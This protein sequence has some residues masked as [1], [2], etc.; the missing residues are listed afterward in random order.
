MDLEEVPTVTQPAYTDTVE[1][2]LE[3]T[4]LKD[5]FETKVSLVTNCKY[6]SKLKT[7]LQCKE[8]SKKILDFETITPDTEKKQTTKVPQKDKTPDSELSPKCDLDENVT[9]KEVLLQEEMTQTSFENILTKSPKDKED[10]NSIPEKEITAVEETA[11]VDK[12]PEEEK[13]VETP[14]LK[15]TPKTSM[16]SSDQV[17]SNNSDAKKEP[18]MEQE[19]KNTEEINTQKKS[20]TNLPEHMPTSDKSATIDLKMTTPQN[21]NTSRNTQ[22]SSKRG[23]MPSNIQNRNE[24]TSE[25]PQLEMICLEDIQSTS[26]MKNGKDISNINETKD[27]DIPPIKDKQQSE[28]INKEI[29]DAKSEVQT[30]GTKGEIHTDLQEH[31]KTD[32]CPNSLGGFTLEKVCKWMSM[33]IYL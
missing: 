23:K 5:T 21:K 19:T 13:K 8:L 2:K 22:K 4:S 26:Q 10:T 24:N 27:S 11:P 32:E 17:E 18:S 30:Q 33:Y 7:H 25:E 20:S 1:N 3:A 12:K 16:Q 14:T 29:F 15:P 31:D 9:C 6:N 28:V